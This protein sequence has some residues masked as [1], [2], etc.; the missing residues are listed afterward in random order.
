MNAKAVIVSIGRYVERETGRKVEA[1]Q[2]RHDAEIVTVPVLIPYP[3]E[4]KTLWSGLWS[5][6]E[7]NKRFTKVTE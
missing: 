3:C 2:L 4:Q 6:Y 5:P 1:H 7:F